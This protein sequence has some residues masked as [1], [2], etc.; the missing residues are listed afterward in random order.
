MQSSGRLRE[1]S[2]HSHPVTPAS[3]LQAKENRFQQV[4]SQEKCTAKPKSFAPS[5]PVASTPRLPQ[6]NPN[7]KTR[8]NT[9]QKRQTLPHTNRPGKTSG[10]T[11]RPPS[12][13]A[14]NKA[15]ARS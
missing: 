4:S 14:L 6:N 12:K 10:N 15:V 11:K 1:S 5:S 13:L 8:P 9:K 3:S 7:P 2:N